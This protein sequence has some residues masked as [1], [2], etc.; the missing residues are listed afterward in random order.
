[1]NKY[2]QQSKAIIATSMASVALGILCL[3]TEA[4]KAA[5]IS[6]SEQI[7]VIKK[8][9]SKPKKQAVMAKVTAGESEQANENDQSVQASNSDNTEALSNDNASVHSVNNSQE[10]ASN[11]PSQQPAAAETKTNSH[12]TYQWMGLNLSYDVY[13]EGNEVLTIPGSSEQITVGYGKRLNKVIPN[14][15][16]KIVIS[17]RLKLA[18]P[19]DNLFCGFPDLESIEGL[20]NLDTSEVTSMAQMFQ[21]NPSL[22]ELDLSSFNTAKVEDMSNM[23]SDPITYILD[24][25]NKLEKIKF[26]AEFVTSSVTTMNSMFFGC[27]NLKE[28]DLINFD[29]SSVNDMTQMFT[30]CKSLKE[31]DLRHFD[32][33][34]VGDNNTLFLADCISL[35]KLILGPKIKLNDTS[36]HEISLSTWTDEFTDS[37][38][39][40][41]EK[42]GHIPR[43]K[44]IWTNEQLMNNYKGS[45]DYD[46]YIILAKPV[47]VRYQDKE[48]KDLEKDDLIDIYG[49]EEKIAIKPKSISGFMLDSVTIDDTE[50]KNTTEANITFDNT[51]HDVTF[52]YEDKPQD[53]R[54]PVDAATV[55]VHYQDAKGNMLA[56]DEVLNGK[57]GEGYVSAVKTIAGYKLVTRPN[58]A[59][60]F[61]TQNPQ[62]VIYIYDPM[63]TENSN[64]PG[65]NKPISGVDN[66]REGQNANHSKGKKL[67]ASQPNQ[68]QTGK[69]SQGSKI[70]TAGNENA[71][72][73]DTQSAKG[74]PQTG[75]VKQ[76]GTMAILLG[77][78]S[79]L[80]GLAGGWIKRRK[81]D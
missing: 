1:M 35:Q 61:F 31:L 17:G 9:K 14:S 53:D 15:V 52:I 34:K 22:K 8:V 39:I 48:G 64:Q 11:P 24:G 36:I 40:N 81:R 75:M 19:V 13:G 46:T 57:V 16:T 44:Y 30:C 23:F 69:P 79:L 54:S 20:T 32:T 77:T 55:T 7:K 25:T 56:P 42:S 21:S 80:V 78:L 41:T 65:Q 45:N 60:G 49:L 51:P 10:P 4:A 62:S 38:W 3:N 59:T 63:E 68:V 2:R 73:K 37:Q 33:S 26:G 18:G 43:G 74:L 71:Q 67:H 72:V 70:T 5:K 12:S 47:T 66:N 50:E 6:S 76:E 29:T 28:L 58:N 27:T